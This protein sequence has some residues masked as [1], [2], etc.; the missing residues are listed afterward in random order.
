M[1]ETYQT[2]FDG[3]QNP[4]ICF[5]FAAEDCPMS[6]SE[7]YIGQ[8]AGGRDGPPSHAPHPRSFHGGLSLIL[9]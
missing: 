3:A 5:S 1:L 2:S 6:G 7:R 8:P 9:F 4:Y